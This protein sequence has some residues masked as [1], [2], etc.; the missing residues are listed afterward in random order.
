MSHFA[1]LILSGQ[2]S[3]HLAQPRYCSSLFIIDSH[4]FA[5]SALV[6]AFP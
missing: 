2:A 1:S 6:S 5:V 4:L 3:P